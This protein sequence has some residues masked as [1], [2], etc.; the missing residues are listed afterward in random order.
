LARD[1]AIYSDWFKKKGDIPKAREQLT[2]AI[3][4]FKQ[5]GADGWVEKYDKELAAIFS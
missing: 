3:G 4:L 5:C 1:H 2:T